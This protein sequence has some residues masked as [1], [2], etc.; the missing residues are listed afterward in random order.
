MRLSYCI[1]LGFGK[2]AFGSNRG[3]SD[4]EASTRPLDQ[5]VIYLWLKLYLIVPVNFLVI[6][7]KNR[8]YN[9]AKGFAELTIG[10]FV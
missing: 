9:K 2:K 10:C 1:H 6:S 3:P 5:R 8:E 7:A 4:C